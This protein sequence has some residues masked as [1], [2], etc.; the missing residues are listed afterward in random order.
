[1]NPVQLLKHL[2]VN[3]YFD[4]DPEVLE[5]VR[6]TLRFTSGLSPVTDYANP[7]KFS[8]LKTGDLFKSMLYSSTIYA[9]KRAKKGSYVKRGSLLEY[10]DKQK[11]SIVYKVRTLS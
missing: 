11:N 10:D 7:L 9:K 2:Y 5:Q 6:N 1:M 4:K 3:K 8:Q